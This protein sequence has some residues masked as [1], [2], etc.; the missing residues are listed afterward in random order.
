[1]NKQHES[2]EVQNFDFGTGDLEAYLETVN[3]LNIIYR[4]KMLGILKRGK[5]QEISEMA[6]IR[7]T[8]DEIMSLGEQGHGFNMTQPFRAGF[9]TVYNMNVEPQNRIPR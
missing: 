5:E 7:N 8:F 1:M 9:I 2:I 4:N 6:E 3:G